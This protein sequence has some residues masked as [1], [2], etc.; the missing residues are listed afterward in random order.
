MAELLVKLT[1][2][3]NAD[4]VKDAQGCYKRGDVV[5]VMPDGHVWGRQE[6]PPTFCV[7][8]VPGLSVEDARKYTE[9]QVEQR[10]TNLAGLQPT[11]VT[12]RLHRLKIDALT[13]AARAEIA[14]KGVV[15]LTRTE[16][17]AAIESKRA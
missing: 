16:A 6:G 9:P 10:M 3:T 2:A 12:R 13:T 14:D 11:M 15:S 1:D 8:K 4:P 17:D 7:V 5:V